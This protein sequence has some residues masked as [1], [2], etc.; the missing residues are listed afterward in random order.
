[1]FELALALDQVPYI[2]SLIHLSRIISLCRQYS[3]YVRPAPEIMVWWCCLSQ[4]LKG[5]KIFDHVIELSSGV[6]PTSMFSTILAFQEAAE[7]SIVRSNFDVLKS[8]MIKKR[9]HGFSSWDC[10]AGV[11]TTLRLLF[12]KSPNRWT[13]TESDRLS[14]ARPQ[15]SQ[16]LARS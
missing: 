3:Q 2:C 10:S 7:A 1:M 5:E 11:E 8:S 6:N 4:T 15:L 9:S 12:I 14:R 13:I 16:I